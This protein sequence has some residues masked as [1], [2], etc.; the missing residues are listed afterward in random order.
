[1]K[2][3][4]LTIPILLGVVSIAAAQAPMNPWMLRFGVGSYTSRDARDT[5]GNNPFNVGLSYNL[6]HYQNM[7][8]A[9]QWIDLDFSTK[10]RNGVR[11]NV[12]GGSYVVRFD[13]G[14][15]AATDFAPYVGLG[16]GFFVNEVRFPNDF[17]GSGTERSTRL[18][19]KGLV[20]ASFAERFGIELGYQSTGSVAG[21]RTD[22]WTIMGV[23]RF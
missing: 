4:L 6:G 19:F 1:M 5:V 12:F 3:G 20:G 9:G 15:G 13:I 22:M 16:V 17:V 7:P 8:N 23:L 10:S 11:A 14:E 18:G 2:K 21:A